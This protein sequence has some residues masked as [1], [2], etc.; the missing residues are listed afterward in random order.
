MSR[1]DDLLF[2]G[3]RSDV[4]GVQCLNDPAHCHSEVLELLAHK[5]GFFYTG[6][7]P[8]DI[9]KR[10]VSSFKSIMNYKGTLVGIKMA[11]TCIQGKNDNVDVIY[12]PDVVKQTGVEEPSYLTNTIDIYV[13]EPI[14]DKHALNQ[15]L[16]YVLP[17]GICY[18]IYIR[19]YEEY[20]K[21][22]FDSSENE[23]IVYV[24]KLDSTGKCVS[25]DKVL[26]IQYPEPFPTVYNGRLV[27]KIKDNA[28]HSCGI[29]EL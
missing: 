2:M 23:Y 17:T 15:L 11:V 6:Y 18:N 5:V 8:Q 1:L 9:L 14:V 21:Y 28:F 4:R 16:K 19:T 7:I 12:E 25:S 27:Y 26:S 29:E 22:E 24:S 20:Y 3:I 13:K 10:I